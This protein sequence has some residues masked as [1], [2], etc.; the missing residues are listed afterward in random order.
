MNNKHRAAMKRA[1]NGMIKQATE[2]D[3]EGYQRKH[4]YLDEYI[5]QGTTVFTYQW[6]DDFFEE[7]SEVSYTATEVIYDLHLE[8]CIPLAKFLQSPGEILFRIMMAKA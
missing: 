8:L 6:Y 1:L 2:V 4:G 5:R 7:D 3:G